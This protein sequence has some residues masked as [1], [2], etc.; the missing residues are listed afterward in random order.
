MPKKKRIANRI[1][2]SDPDSYRRYKKWR[3]S[4]TYE[5]RHREARNAKK[6]ERMA[7]LRAKQKMDS[8]IVQAA[9][10]AAK[11][12]SARKYRE[13]HRLDIAIR[14]RLARYEAKK[15]RQNAQAA[16]TLLSMRQRNCL[17]RALW[18]IEPNEW[19]QT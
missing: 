16:D 11:E 5:A 7:A 15:A 9:R 17:D 6:R 8:P 18:D 12:E 13:N 10:L 14:A 4:R 19:D 1:D 2:E 3:S